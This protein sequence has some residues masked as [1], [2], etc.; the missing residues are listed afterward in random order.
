M[1]ESITPPRL[2]T[3][4]QPKSGWIA[5][6]SLTLLLTLMEVSSLAITVPHIFS[7]HMVLQQKRAVPVWGWAAPNESIKVSGS[8][9]E[10]SAVAKADGEGK[11]Q[12]KLQTP[13][14]RRAISDYHIRQQRN[15][16]E[17]CIDR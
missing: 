15:C 14:R 5:V 11:W 10:E 7:D 16:L 6:M 17:R 13:C 2:R 1:Q 4:R 3:Y 8:W 12:V 9:S